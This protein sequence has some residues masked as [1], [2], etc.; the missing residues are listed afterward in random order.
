MSAGTGPDGGLCMVVHQATFQWGAPTSP[1]GDP[2]DKI[3]ISSLIAEY[4]VG[5]GYITGLT[6]S[7]STL[8]LTQRKG[9]AEEFQWITGTDSTL[10]H[11]AVLGSG[12]F[13]TVHKVRSILQK[14]IDFEDPE[15]HYQTG[16]MD[17]KSILT[18]G[19]CEKDFSSDR[20]GYSRRRQQ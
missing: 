15:C 4:P 7:P 13:G 14:P 1:A 19:L 9:M 18:P 6:Q 3:K 5:R 10:L 17:A 2:G 12:T 16:A 8:T 20:P 11:I